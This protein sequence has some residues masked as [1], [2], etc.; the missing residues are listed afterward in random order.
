MQPTTV[1]SIRKSL[2]NSNATERP[3]AAVPKLHYSN[4]SKAFSEK[5]KKYDKKFRPYYG[6][7]PVEI[8]IDFHVLSFGDIN[9]VE[10]VR[11][12]SISP[13]NIVHSQVNPFTRFMCPAFT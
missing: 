2:Q 3:R 7:K 9:E 12:A 5:L 1:F 4:V 10:M 13:K 6:E 11:T 8:I